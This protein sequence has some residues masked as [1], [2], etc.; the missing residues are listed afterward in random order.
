ME[1][2]ATGITVAVKRRE[3]LRFYQANIPYLL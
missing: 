2:L 1:G 3:A